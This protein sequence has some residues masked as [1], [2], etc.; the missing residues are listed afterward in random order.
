MRDRCA[1]P[2]SVPTDGKL[3]DLYLNANSRAEAPEPVKGLARSLTKGMT[4]PFEKAQ[5][6]R[7]EIS[8]R[9][10][11]NLRAPVTPSGADPVEYAL[12]LGYCARSNVTL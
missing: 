12:S 7:S 11:Y 10:I 8:K 5:A 3:V 6:I 4:D 2:L 9:I 1:G